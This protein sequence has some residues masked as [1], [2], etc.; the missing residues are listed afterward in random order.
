MMKKMVLICVFSLACSDPLEFHVAEQP[1]EP[2][3]ARGAEATPG[4]LQG[5][6]SVVFDDA[7]NVPV[8]TGNGEQDAGTAP[9]MDTGGDADTDVDSDVDSDT[10]SDGDSDT[11]TDT[12]TES[13][14]ATDS[15]EDAGPDG[16]AD[17]DTETETET[18]TGPS[19]DPCD[20]PEL[21]QYSIVCVDELCPEYQHP[22]EPSDWGFLW[23]EANQ[24]FSSYPAI[25][26]DEQIAIYWPSTP[27]TWRFYVPDYGC[28]RVN[29]PDGWTT[30][31]PTGTTSTTKIT[32][33]GSCLVLECFGCDEHI[34]GV[35]SILGLE[36]ESGASPGWVH[37]VTGPKNSGATGCD[38]KCP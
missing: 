26:N 6:E 24:D 10:D 25:G 32:V 27:M 12:D 29:M 20:S 28:I 8:D 4:E 1:N 5:D 15:E 19:L 22:E 16:Q 18:V 3:Q 36:P 23:C 33:S 21:E 13:D 31:N 17:T 38:L 37:I 35:R 11:D 7:G 30:T 14:T 34:Q 9:E 2:E